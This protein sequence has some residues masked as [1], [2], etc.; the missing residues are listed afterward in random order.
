MHEFEFNENKPE[1][2]FFIFFLF[3]IYHQ[4]LANINKIVTYSTEPGKSTW[5]GKNLKK[6]NKVIKLKI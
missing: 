4:L 2:E 3:F 5:Y 1:N 6:N